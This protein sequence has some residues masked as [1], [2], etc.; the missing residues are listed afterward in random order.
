MRYADNSFVSNPGSAEHILYSAKVLPDGS[1]QL[2]ECGKENLHDIIQ[3]YK[4]TTDMA[5]ILAKLQSGDMSVI[6][7]RPAMYGDFTQYPKTLADALQLQIDSRNLFDRLPAEIKK[8]FD[9]DPNKFFAASGTNEWFEKI[10]PALSEEM[11]NVI[12][13]AKVEEP[14]VDQEVKE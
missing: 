11:K 4:D 6:N 7:Q 3:S 14:V 8:K 1:I 2:K 13:P 9:N 10:E 12:F 5:Y